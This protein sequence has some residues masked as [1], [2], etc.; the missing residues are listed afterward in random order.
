MIQESSVLIR[1]NI[2]SGINDLKSMGLKARYI[3]IN[4]FDIAK[5]R[6]ELNIN[7]DIEIKNLYGL[8]VIVDAS[9]ESLRIV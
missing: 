1:D 7:F 6:E 4:D 8:S 3:L 5:L 2:K 9:I